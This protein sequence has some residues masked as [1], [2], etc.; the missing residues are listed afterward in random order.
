MAMKTKHAGAAVDDDCETNA[1]KGKLG[2]GYEKRKPKRKAAAVSTAPP[3]QAAPEA[4]AALAR[5]L[6]KEE[7]DTEQR[8]LKAAFTEQ[9]RI[10]HS[11]GYAAIFKKSS[12]KAVAP[13]AVVSQPEEPL[14]TAEQ[15]AA[16][17]EPAL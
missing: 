15:A 5:T 16:E 4:E 14:S 13:E 6:S 17:Q 2:Y 1:G 12:A 9:Q 10:F 3:P 8:Q 7:W 11:N